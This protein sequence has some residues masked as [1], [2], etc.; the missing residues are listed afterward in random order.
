MDR[1]AW[2]ATVHGVAQTRTQLKQSNVL[3]RSII[4]TTFYFSAMLQSKRDLSSASRDQTRAPLQ[5]KPGVLTAGASGK[6]SFYYYG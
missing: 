1:G 4:I 5:W 2:W 6:S 3:A